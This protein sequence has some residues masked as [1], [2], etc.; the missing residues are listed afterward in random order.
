[1]VKWKKG[2]W[3]CEKCNAEFDEYPGHDGDICLICGMHTDFTYV[4]YVGGVHS[5]GLGWSPNGDYCGECNHSCED[6]LVWQ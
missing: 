3:Y 2:K 5:G 6:C 1:M 4:D